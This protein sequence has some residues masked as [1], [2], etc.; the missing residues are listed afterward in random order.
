VEWRRDRSGALH[1]MEINPRLWGSLP[2][3]IAAGVDM[4]RGLLALARGETPGPSPAWRVGFTARNLSED[5]SWMVN[6]LRAD[7]RD[8]LLLTE[9]PLRAAFCWLRV[10]TGR[11]AWDGWSWRDAAVGIEELLRL[12]RSRFDA[13]SR[14]VGKRA[15]LARARRN[16]M[17]IGRTPGALARPIGSVL[18]LC[19]GNLC[20][21]PFAEVATARRLPD[22]AVES[23]GFLSHDGRPSP[24]HVVTVARMLGVDVSASR[25]RRVTA[26]QIAAADLIVCMDVSH[27]ERMAA[28]FPQALAK[29]TLLGLFDA[30]GPVEMKDPYDMSPS[31][32]LAVF[33]D[34]LRAIDALASNAA[35][36]VSPAVAS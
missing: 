13:L 30:D 24:A 27:L 11:E 16:H 7:R 22:V 18:F 8:P 29:T 32:T 19:L 17:A 28:E 25:A 35:R 10:L 2:L 3:T 34:M 23:A 6:N 12:V 9:P 33:E 5:I 26:D 15:A 31:A 36:P 4:P 20:R 1:L 21:S 14:R